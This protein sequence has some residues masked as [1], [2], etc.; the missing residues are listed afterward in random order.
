MGQCMRKIETFVNE[1]LEME[2]TMRYEDLEPTLPPSLRKDYRPIHY[3]NAP[4]LAALKETEEAAAACG[5]P[6][7]AAVQA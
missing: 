4:T 3:Y 1:Q 2:R 5:R 7:K 6:V